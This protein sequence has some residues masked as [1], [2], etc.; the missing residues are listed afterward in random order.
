M[1]VSKR[2]KKNGKSVKKKGTLHIDPNKESAVTLQDL[3][4]VLAYQESL[5]PDDDPTKMRRPED[6]PDQVFFEEAPTPDANGEY[7]IADKNRLKPCRGINRNI[8]VGEGCF[9]EACLDRFKFT[10]HS[11][12]FDAEAVA[13]VISLHENNKMEDQK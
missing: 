6:A 10:D 3:I 1:P 9:D 4:N 12:D 8:C 2:R 5:K 7:D 13:K 11:E